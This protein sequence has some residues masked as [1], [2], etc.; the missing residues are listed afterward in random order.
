MK[1]YVYV[2]WDYV[3]P[4]K[5][6]TRK[7][8]FTPLEWLFDALASRGGETFL[9]TRTN[10]DDFRVFFHFSLFFAR[11]SWSHC[12]GMSQII[13]QVGACTSSTDFKPHVKSVTGSDDDLTQ[14][15]EPSLDWIFTRKKFP[16]KSLEQAPGR[17][18][19]RAH[20]E[21]SEEGKTLC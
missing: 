12:T 4:H 5:R 17:G 9:C 18:S 16:G 7:Q 8:I 3:S 1:F 10:L 21:A 6:W 13:H 20:G 15:I 11:I 19:R 14:V 2:L